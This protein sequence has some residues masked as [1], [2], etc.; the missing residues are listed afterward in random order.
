MHVRKS[1]VEFLVLN[2]SPPTRSSPAKAQYPKFIDFSAQE[3]MLSSPVIALQ[4]HFKQGTLL[5]LTKTPS[6]K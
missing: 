5:G 3:N 1:M 4:I 6:E 2:S